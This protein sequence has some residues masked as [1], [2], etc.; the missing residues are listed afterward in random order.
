[1]DSDPLV[2]DPMVA[3]TPWSGFA[4]RVGTVTLGK[5][6]D[7]RTLEQVDIVMKNGIVHVAPGAHP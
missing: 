7:V 4:D 2:A 3:L 1:M 6:A 5:R